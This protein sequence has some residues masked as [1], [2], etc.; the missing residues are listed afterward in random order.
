MGAIGAAF[1]HHISNISRQT[2]GT[3][4]DAPVVRLSLGADLW[5]LCDSSLL[6][7]TSRRYPSY[8]V[9]ALESRNIF[10]LH[11]VPLSGEML[12]LAPAERFL[13][14][15]FLRQFQAL[16]GV[17]IT[18][19]PFLCETSLA[20]VL[21]NDTKTQILRSVA[22]PPRTLLDWVK[23][24]TAASRPDHPVSFSMA[25]PG[26][27]SAS[28]LGLVELV[29]EALG[30]LDA[31]HLRGVSDAQLSQ[32]I[33]QLRAEAK[34]NGNSDRLEMYKFLLGQYPPGTVLLVYDHLAKP[35]LNGNSS[36]ATVI[37]PEKYFHPVVQTVIMSKIPHFQLGLYLP[38]L[39]NSWAATGL[40]QSGVF[41][42]PSG[43]LEPGINCVP[44]Y[45][46]MK[47]VLDEWT[48]RQTAD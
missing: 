40:V 18:P 44:D 8:S 39:L 27:C 30:N 16:P 48:S 42:T 34:V 13:A 21:S 19:G 12:V 31:Q 23:A 24:C 6:D 43:S 9:E 3:P 33:S 2:V 35:L 22:T 38:A 36:D 5:T 47:R 20:L 46:L 41:T 11:D 15:E 32:V 4:P 25:D 10:A 17:K 45:K 14:E 37:I 1:L 26:K 29:S 7:F 28:W